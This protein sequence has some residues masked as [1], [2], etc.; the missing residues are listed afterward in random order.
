MV[1]RKSKR[2]RSKPVNRRHGA[3]FHPSG[4]SRVGLIIFPLVLLLI[5]GLIAFG[6]Y[7]FANRRISDFRSRAATHRPDFSLIMTMT[8]NPSTMQVKVRDAKVVKSGYVPPRQ[9]TDIPRDSYYGKSY[10]YVLSEKLAFLEVDSRKVVFSQFMMDPP[11]LPGET[12]TEPVKLAEPEAYVTIAYMPGAAFWLTGLDSGKSVRL[13]DDKIDRAYKTAEPAGPESEVKTIFDPLKSDTESD[14]VLGAT[15]TDGFV[16]ILFLSSAYSDFN[17]FSSDVQAMSSKL[18]ATNPFSVKSSQIRLKQLNNSADLGCYYDGRCI[19]CNTSAVLAAA[20][21]TSYDT[22]MV[23]HNNNTY[24]G[25]A[26]LGGYAMTYRNV[27]EYAKEVMVHELGHSFG[28]LWDEYSYGYTGTP[29]SNAPNCDAA[30]CAKWSGI[31][32]TACSAPC[33]Y[34]NAYAPAT[35][36]IMRTLW[37]PVWRFDPVCVNQL[38][39]RI[40]TVAGA[41]QPGIT[42]TPTPVVTPTPTPYRTPT[43]TPPP[44]TPTSNPFVSPTRTPTP[45]VAPPYVP[46][47][48]NVTGP[49]SATVRTKVSY[50]A[51]FESEKGSLAGEI[52]YDSGNRRLTRIKY[53]PIKTNTGSLTAVWNPPAAGSYQVCCRAWYDGISSCLPSQYV[54]RA[55]Q[56]ACAG[57]A[58][59]M[60]VTV[61]TPT[62]TP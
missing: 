7:F 53:Q 31:A 2:G 36:C 62:P 15:T 23:V 33:T 1:S 14:S 29:P 37:A 24:G 13:P 39:G 41:A 43:P 52:F 44:A 16:D 22:V 10:E 54:T 6:L 34:T 19:L 25:C 48:W 49:A 3:V 26:Y 32:G 56:Y 18:L 28:I 46:N 50:T 51:Q 57:P 20:A 61:N 30:A 11:P 60:T 21:A 42:P 45:T 58:S 5:F 12:A 27:N 35:D 55:G 4:F 8:L 47:C 17:V 9:S 40:D 38:S 59:C